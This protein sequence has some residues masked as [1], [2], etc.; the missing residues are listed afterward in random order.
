MINLLDAEIKQGRAKQAMNTVLKELVNYVD[1]HFGLEESMLEAVEYN[2]LEKH[3]AVHKAFTQNILCKY[4]RLQAGKDVLSLSLV[5][6]LQEWIV[7]HVL[8]VD[9]KYAPFLKEKSVTR[10]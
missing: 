3:K 5:T 4:D 9:K 7:D 2:D 1:Q 6:E 10:F 8:N